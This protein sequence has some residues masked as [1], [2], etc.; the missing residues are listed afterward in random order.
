MMRL[1]LLVAALLVLSGARAQ[2]GP[3]LQ[4][5]IDGAF[6][7]GFGAERDQPFPLEMVCPELAGDGRL[8]SLPLQ[9]PLGEDVTPAQL[10]D[11][12]ALHQTTRHLPGAVNNEADPATLSPILKQM[13]TA[14]EEPG[15]WE[16]F[17]AWLLEHLRSDDEAQSWLV[18]WLDNVEIDEDTA[19]L[20]FGLLIVAIVL[21]GVGVVLNELMK[22]DLR[23]SGSTARR[24]RLHPGDGLQGDAPDWQTIASLPAGQQ[25]AAAL[26]YLL[27]ALDRA[28]I[29]PA[30]RAWTY[31]EYAKAIR[32]RL[33]A[34]ANAFTH[35][36]AAA[37]MAVYGNREPSERESRQLLASA[38]AVK[39]ALEQGA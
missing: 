20:I 8:E 21:M 16:R 17:R 1:L 26:R 4:Q 36:T 18:E 28:N 11:L 10:L 13:D 38:E 2:T 14:S 15:L 7:D 12:R 32:S 5:C 22:A 35:L 33:P 27:E 3:S 25:P 29:I 34:V 19:T 39:H 24:S 31:R 9:A 30:R 23:F 37:E 6:A